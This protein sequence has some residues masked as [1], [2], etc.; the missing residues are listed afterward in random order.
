MKLV[1]PIAVTPAS[2]SSSTVPEDEPV[3]SAAT[4]YAAGAIVRGNAT[5]IEHRLFESV[6]GSNINHPLTD[7]AWWIDAGPTNR[8]RMFD[9][10]VQTQSENPD[11]VEVVIRTTS[12]IDSVA[13]LN[14]DAASV[15]I[16]MT[17]DSEGDV[18][19]QTF[20]LVST[21]GIV[22]WYSYFYE[23]IERRRDLVVMDL[24]PYANVDLTVAVSAPAGVAKVGALVVGLS[25]QI[26]EASY[27]ARVGILDFS[28]KEK[29]AFGNFI[30]VE[31][32][33]SKR[34]T[35]TVT[36]D[37]GLTDHVQD[38][39]ARYRA[40]PLVYVGSERFGSTIL[41]GY[42]RDFQVEIAGPNHSV[43]SLELE[44]LA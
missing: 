43:C 20:S 21:D 19:S 31:R 34:A 15:E 3:W 44:G 41:Y 27:G 8:W 26:G 23:P 13:L 17:D 1:R 33:F 11:E 16:V 4:T 38:L 37:S 32:A 7:G 42:Y 12:R 6:Q 18:Y 14:L 40:T 2:L 10:S 29:D 35:F 30:V 5:D 22:D 24:P 25:R 36:M 28:R 39:L 9:G